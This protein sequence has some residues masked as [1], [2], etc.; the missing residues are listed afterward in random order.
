METHSSY[1][2]KPIAKIM[3]M[4]RDEVLRFADGLNILNFQRN[5]IRMPFTFFREVI[6]HS[7]NSQPP[8]VYDDILHYI[9]G[10]TVY[11]V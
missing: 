3:D 5:W 7:D 8:A 10:L 1:K 2:N 11:L 6:S 9:I 4:I